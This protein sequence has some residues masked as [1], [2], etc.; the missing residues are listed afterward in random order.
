MINKG[1]LLDN[2][3]RSETYDI[4]TC[5]TK[6]HSFSGY[7]EVCTHKSFVVRLL[8]LLLNKLNKIEIVAFLFILFEGQEE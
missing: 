3:T 2:K 7:I 1:H 5:T 6:P 8:R 4:E